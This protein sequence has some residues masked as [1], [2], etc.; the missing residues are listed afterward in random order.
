MLSTL[1]CCPTNLDPVFL[2]AATSLMTHRRLQN[3]RMV[4]YLGETEEPPGSSKTRIGRVEEWQ[5]GE[6]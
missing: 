4:M 6:F 3:R 2:I 5:L 1:T